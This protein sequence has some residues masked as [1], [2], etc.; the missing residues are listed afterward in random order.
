MILYQSVHTHRHR[1]I[2]HCILPVILR[3]ICCPKLLL[4]AALSRIALNMYKEFLSNLRLKA[5]LN[6]RNS[7]QDRLY[8]PPQS[9]YLFRQS[10]L[11]YYQTNFQA[12]HCNTNPFPAHIPPTQQD[13]PHTVQAYMPFQSYP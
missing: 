13:N 12:I 1:M 3:N 11:T 2:L 4:P 10:A 7:N 6:Q 8:S 9:S 5:Y